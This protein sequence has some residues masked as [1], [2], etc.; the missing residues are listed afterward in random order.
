MVPNDMNG[1]YLR[2]GPN[3]RYHADSGRG[4][5]FDGDSM[6]HGIRIKSGKAYYCNQRTQTEKL[7]AELK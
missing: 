4:H 5:F 2:N 1:V 6:I 3:A 7:I